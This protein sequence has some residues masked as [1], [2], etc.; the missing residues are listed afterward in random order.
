MALNNPTKLRRNVGARV[1]ALRIGR[2]W[3]QE[4]LAEQIDVSPRYLQAVEGGQENLTLDSLVKIAN[5]LR[6]RVPALFEPPDARHGST[7]R[8]VVRK[9]P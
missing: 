8:A 9:R 1:A 6:V 5:V 4:A 3:T 7:A 2:G